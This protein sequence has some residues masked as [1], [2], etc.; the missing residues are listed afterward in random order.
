MMAP[1]DRTY[2]SSA[3]SHV[4]GWTFLFP[5]SSFEFSAVLRNCLSMSMMKTRSWVVE[6]CAAIERPMSPAPPVTTAID[7]DE[8]DIIMVDR[9]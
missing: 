9:L 7:C 4:N 3:M 5:A 2:V 6:R 1:I 8:E